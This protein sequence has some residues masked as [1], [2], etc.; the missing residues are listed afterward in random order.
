[1]EDVNW[2]KIPLYKLYYLNNVNEFIALSE[3]D[4]NRLRKEYTDEEIQRLSAALAW[5]SKNP[6]YDFSSLLPNLR[7]K[8]HD[9][10][11]YLCKVY[12]SFKV[13]GG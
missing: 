8:N 13:G 3:E 9:I 4:L 10:H 1:M 6:D 5:A 2:L 7:H 11:A 12:E